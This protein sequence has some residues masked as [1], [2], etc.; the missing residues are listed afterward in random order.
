MDICVF[1]GKKTSTKTKSDGFLTEEEL[2]YWS[3]NYKVDENDIPQLPVIPGPLISLRKSKV[4]HRLRTKYEG[5][6]C[7]YRCLTV[8][9]GRGY[10]SHLSQVSSKEGEGIPQSLV[11]GPFQVVYLLSGLMSLLEGCT[12]VS[13]PMSLLGE[14]GTLNRDRGYF[15]HPTQ[16]W[17]TPSGQV[18]ECC[19]ATGG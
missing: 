15:P 4:C 2:M 18:S 5:R 13:G 11:Q 10:P 1:L 12:P 19:Y 7:F 3:A 8:S 9:R 16:D 6:L 17:G 14:E